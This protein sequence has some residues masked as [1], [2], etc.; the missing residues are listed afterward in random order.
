[1]THQSDY[2]LVCRSLLP[3]ALTR[4]AIIVFLPIREGLVGE[5]LEGRKAGALRLYLT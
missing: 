4:S 3:P 1:M 2:V 5:L